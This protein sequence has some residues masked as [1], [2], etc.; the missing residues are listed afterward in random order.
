M[1]ESCKIKV[2][3]QVDRESIFIVTGSDNNITNV[4]GVVAPPDYYQ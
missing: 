1:F 3:D 4:D 2:I